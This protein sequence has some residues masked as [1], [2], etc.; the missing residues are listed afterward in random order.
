MIIAGFAAGVVVAGPFEV[1]FID[2]ELTTRYL[3]LAVS[4]VLAALVVFDIASRASSS[5]WLVLAIIVGAFAVV[6]ALVDP[7]WMRDE[8]NELLYFY[9]T[10]SVLGGLVGFVGGS[11]ERL[12]RRGLALALIWVVT[13]V[14]LAIGFVEYE[15]FDVPFYLI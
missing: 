3:A 8:I 2:R 9:W 4:M 10:G 13:L 12:V 14:A 1:I 15:Q 6:L 5:R 11:G 7:F